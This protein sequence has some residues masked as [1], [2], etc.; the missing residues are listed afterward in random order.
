[1]RGARCER[2]GRIPFTRI[3]PADAGSTSC[4]LPNV[5]RITDHPRGCGEHEPAFTLNVISSGSSPRMRGALSW[6]AC[7]ICQ[8][9]IIPADAGSTPTSRVCDVSIQDHPR[10]CG[11][12]PTQIDRSW[13]SEGSSPRMRGAPGQRRA[14]RVRRRTIPA[15][16]GSTSPCRCRGWRRR[17]HPRG[18]GEHI[19]FAY[20]TSTGLGSSPRMRGAQPMQ[21]QPLLL[22]RIIPADAGSTWRG[23][24]LA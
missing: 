2:I 3:I 21:P 9:R 6:L 17:D 8:S 1:M 4:R 16:A 13:M 11:E 20:R 10:G 24:S 7:T 18:C 22:P 12:H 23:S 19:T 14:G 15:D 5:L